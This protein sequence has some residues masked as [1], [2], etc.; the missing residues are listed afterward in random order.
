M[1]QPKHV[2]PLDAH[3][4]AFPSDSNG[5]SKDGLESYQLEFQRKTS[6][7]RINGHFA[8]VSALFVVKETNTSVPRRELIGFHR[9]LKS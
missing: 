5:N 3:V 4:R 9:I 8:S 1:N 7:R 6:S 2:G